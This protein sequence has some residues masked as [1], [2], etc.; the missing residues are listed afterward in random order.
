MAPR[1]LA[2]VLVAAEAAWHAA[3][4]ELS[5]SGDVMALVQHTI[6]GERVLAT[7]HEAPVVEGEPPIYLAGD[8]AE[9]FIETGKFAGTWA[10]VTIVKTSANGWYD[11][12]M[13]AGPPPH[14]STEI[15][16][17]RYNYLRQVSPEDFDKSLTAF[18]TNEEANVMAT[19]ADREAQRRKR[20]AAALRKSRDYAK[21]VMGKGCPGEYIVQ[22]GNVPGGDHYG[23]GSRILHERIEGCAADCDKKSDCKAFHWD[24][25]STICQLKKKGEP[26]KGYLDARYMLCQK[27]IFEDTSKAS[28]PEAS[29][30]A[31]SA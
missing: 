21:E 1:I 31:K 25:I 18:V 13:E 15:S 9:V 29:T 3:A 26:T 28:S 30:T 6:G 23:H 4:V 19:Q 14:N 7:V 5:N 17:V 2:A 11:V 16:G 27:F 20:A 24:P 10:P 22:D 12:R 8:G